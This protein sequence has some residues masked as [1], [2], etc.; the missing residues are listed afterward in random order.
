MSARRRI[1][2]IPDQMGFGGLVPNAV[3]TG[4]RAASAF[5]SRTQKNAGNVGYRHSFFDLR[6]VISWL[7]RSR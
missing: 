2:L 5:S 3:R 6:Q 1:D 4:R 7:R